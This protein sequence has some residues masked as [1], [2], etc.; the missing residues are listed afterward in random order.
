[1]SKSWIF[2]GAALI[3]AIIFRLFVG[4]VFEVSSSNMLPTLYINDS[5]FVSKIA[6]LNRGDVV[7]FRSP[8]DSKQI[9]AA[10]IL[11]VAK[12]KIWI[13]EGELILNDHIIEKHIPNHL[14]YQT[15]WMSTKD[16]PG[17]VTALDDYVHWQETL[18]EKEHGILL[19]KEASVEQMPLMVIPEDRFF[20]I[21]DNRFGSEDSRHWPEDKRFVLRSEIL[22]RVERVLWSCGEKLSLV[23]FFCDPRTMRWGRLF[24]KVE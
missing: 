7:V 1:M 16:F 10:R 6:N 24:L 2:V 15:E 19:K 14:K 17:Q 3:L 22:G 18:P 21:G 5:V 8:L 4:E 9:F 12:D 13:H 20:L 23:P 11:A